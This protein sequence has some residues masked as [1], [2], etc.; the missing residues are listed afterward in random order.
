[1]ARKPRTLLLAL[2]TVFA[3]AT[4]AVF[5]FTARPVHPRPPMPDPNGYD[6]FLKAITLVNRN[7]PTNLSTLDRNALQAWV[8]TNSESLRLLRLGLTRE[9]ARFP[10]PDP[11]V[12]DFTKWLRELAYMELLAVRLRAEGRLYEMDNRVADAAKSY[13]DAIH[14]GNEV[15]RGGFII[16]RVVGMHIEGWGATSLSKLVPKLNSQ[17][18]RMVLDELAKIERRRVTWE[19]V[20]QNESQLR[21]RHFIEWFHPIE[22]TRWLWQTRGIARRAEL[23]HKK[24]LAHLRL[25]MAELA[26]RCYQ[27]EQGHVPTGLKDLV[28]KYLQ[29]VPPDPLSGSPMLYHLHG[30]NWLLYSVGEDGVDDGGRPPTPSVPG[31]VTRGD[32]FY[33]STYY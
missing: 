32:L 30:T 1:M 9:I 8:S 16:G 15:S 24:Q 13:A 7:Y 6:D 14:F 19:E 21:K 20:R 27:S 33:D 26:V 4:V 31:T 29:Q 23:N 28:P 22:L 10:D 17:D 18:A 12:E 25:L 11:H 5:F 3:L 2:I